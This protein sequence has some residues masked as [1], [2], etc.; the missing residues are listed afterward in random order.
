MSVCVCQ[1][2]VMSVSVSC[3]CVYNKPV[4]CGYVCAWGYINEFMALLS[5]V[6]DMCIHVGLRLCWSGL[7]MYG[8]VYRLSVWCLVSMCM[9]CDYGLLI[10]HR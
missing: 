9:Y 7:S 6:G 8:C 5:L 4:T 2:P 3:Q 10:R 1:W